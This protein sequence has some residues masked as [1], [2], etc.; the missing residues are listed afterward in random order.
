[1]QLQPLV[2]Q[3]IRWGWLVVL[4]AVLAGLAALLFTRLA[5]PT[6]RATTT[7]SLSGSPDS[8]S[9]ALDAGGGALLVATYAQLLERRPV[10][11]ELNA[12][13]GLG[14][15]PERLARRLAV[16]PVDGTLMFT[17][18]ADAATPGEAALLAGTAAEVLRANGPRMLGPGLSRV[19]L[20]V[21]EPATPPLRPVAPRVP[22]VVAVAALLGALLSAG[23]VALRYA[24]TGPAETADDLR[25]GAGLAVLAAIPPMRN[26]DAANADLTGAAPSPAGDAVRQLRASL[27]SR[28]PADAPWALAVTSPRHGDGKSAVAA[29][30]AASLA[31]SGRRVILVDANLRRPALHELFG[32]PND[33]GLATALRHGAGPLDEQ[34]A[35]TAV[36]DL[37]LLPAG[38]GAAN[39][40]EFLASRELEPLL[41]ALRARADVVVVDCGPV[42]AVADGL[43]AMRHCDAAL[44]VA[45]AGASRTHELA[46]ARERI[47]QAGVRVVGAV[48]MG[49][50]GG[51]WSGPAR[52]PEAPP[53]N[54]VP[55]GVEAGRRS[56]GD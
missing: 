46:Q 29:R 38:P 20:A 34:L 50:R 53:R 19:R 2:R 55:P 43:D 7:L 4:G 18:S 36:P 12:R 26:G 42:V 1:M 51:G 5:P 22:L 44:L 21:I 23:A 56:T 35:R 32:L 31:H 16:E 28:M 39:A 48:L 11:D 41:A 27:V 15:S 10:L 40:A 45:R 3:L 8:S 52:A 17:L 24:L 6:Y 25:S 33:R 37:R 47:E 14:L 54:L 49:T 13:L 9:G 30:L